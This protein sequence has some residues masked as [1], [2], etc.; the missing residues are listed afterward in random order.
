MHEELDKV[1]HGK[2]YSL[3]LL[4]LDQQVLYSK[5]QVYHQINVQISL[6]KLIII[7]MGNLILTIIN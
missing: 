4:V 1:L 7:I 2:V 3:D 6:V 5:Y